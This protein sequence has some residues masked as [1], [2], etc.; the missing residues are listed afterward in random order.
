MNE[1]TINYL[2][3]ALIIL[4]LVY[5]DCNI[6]NSKKEKMMNFDYCN[7]II[8]QARRDIFKNHTIK[9]RVETLLKE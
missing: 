2:L 8:K 7:K 5:Q 6:K 3:V 4:Y 1:N 9:K